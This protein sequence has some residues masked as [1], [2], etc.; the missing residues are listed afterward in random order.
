MTQEDNIRKALML[1]FSVNPSFNWTWMEGPQ[2]HQYRA[3]IWNVLTGDHKTVPT[4]KIRNQLW[5][6]LGVEGDSLEAKQQYF[7]NK[8]EEVIA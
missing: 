4:G 2:H 6:E 1:I 7:L 5:H 3:T 8:V